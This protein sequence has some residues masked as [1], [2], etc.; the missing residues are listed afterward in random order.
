MNS[1]TPRTDEAWVKAM[2]FPYEGDADE[3]FINFARQLERELA[4]AKAKLEKF[5]SLER[6]LDRVLK[7]P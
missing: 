6:P 7:T 5:E 3:F 1:D 2:T 4:E